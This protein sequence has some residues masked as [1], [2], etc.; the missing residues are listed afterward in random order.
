MQSA[1]S[2]RQPEFGADGFDFGGEFGPAG[3][4]CFEGLGDLF[5]RIRRF[6]ELVGIGDA[7]VAGKMLGEGDLGG[8]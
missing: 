7:F 3:V 4:A 5:D 6:P 2:I 8:L 1:A